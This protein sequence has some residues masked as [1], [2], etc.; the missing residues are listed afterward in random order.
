[1]KCWHS[2]TDEKLKYLVSNLSQCCFIH[3]KFT[4]TAL[5]LNPGLTVQRP[6]T[7]RPSHSMAMLPLVCRAIPVHEMH[8]WAVT[9][10]VHMATYV[11]LAEGLGMV[12]S[13]TAATDVVLSCWGAVLKTS[14]CKCLYSFGML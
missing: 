5:K 2:E 14:F 3:H 7:N 12:I 13:S 9:W 1:M 4:L 10:V 11:T 6:A 8:C